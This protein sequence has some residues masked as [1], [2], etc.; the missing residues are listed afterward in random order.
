MNTEAPDQDFTK[1]QQ[2]LKLKRYEQPHPRYFNDFSGQVISR[3][4]AGKTGSR[5]ETPNHSA[6]RTS[7]LRQLWRNVEAQP[8]LA[9][10]IATVACG[11]VVAGGFMLG[12][13][14]PEDM[15]FMAVG[16]N[17]GQNGLGSSPAMA[18]NFAAAA[19][20]SR[21]VSSTNVS[22]FPAGP[23]LFQNMPSLQ[24]VPAANDA[25]LLPR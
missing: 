8:A 10:V 18:N 3:I 14:T 2:L 17:A 15:S 11:L 5:F 12:G 16:T 9:G 20:D 6:A 4:R 7:W 21:L 25:P 23:N 13:G 19:G 22:P 1:L 24:T